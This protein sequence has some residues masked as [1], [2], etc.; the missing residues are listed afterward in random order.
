[1]QPADG[2][3]KDR[4]EEH[5]LR[6]PPFRSTLPGQVEDFPRNNP[7]IHASFVGHSTI[8]LSFNGIQVLVD[9]NFSNRII[10]ARRVV[11]L[12]FKPEEVKD[13]DLF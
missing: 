11:A 8:L 9:P 4:G 7:G 13:L 10:I 5:R 3:G 2:S 12:P 6:N 1:M